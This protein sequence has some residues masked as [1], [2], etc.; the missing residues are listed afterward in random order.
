MFI[1]LALFSVLA[2]NIVCHFEIDVI[3]A[4]GYCENMSYVRAAKELPFLS[5]EEIEQAAVRFGFVPA[6]TGISTVREDR[7]EKA[8][9]SETSDPEKN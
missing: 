3:F 5:N 4:K 2:I 9:S 6:D 8:S 1:L 7:A